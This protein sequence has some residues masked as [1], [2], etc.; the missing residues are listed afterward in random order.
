[1]QVKCEGCGRHHTVS[2]TGMTV[3]IAA[4]QRGDLQRVTS[5]GVEV[6]CLGDALVPEAV[7]KRKPS[8]VITVDPERWV[9]KA[10]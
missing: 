6:L 9:E 3:I 10:A 5:Q 1:M 8:T 2:P 4:F 7:T